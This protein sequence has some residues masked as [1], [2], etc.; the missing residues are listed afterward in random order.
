MRRSTLLSRWLFSA[1]L[2]A[3]ALSF[4][5]VPQ[6][7]PRPVGVFTEAQAASGRALFTIRAVLPAMAPRLRAQA[8]RP[9]SPEARSC[10]SGAR[11]W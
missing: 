10:S 9:R 6:T 7:P 5:A 1:G 3:L 4:V 8:M 11:R 2:G